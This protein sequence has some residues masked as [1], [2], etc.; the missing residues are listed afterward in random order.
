MAETIQ[1]DVPRKG[2][3]DD[4]AE[5]LRGAGLVAEVRDEGEHCAIH[6]S[7]ADDERSRLVT[8]VAHVVESWLGEQMLPL[9]VE[10]DNGGVAVRPPAE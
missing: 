10:R 2:I 7:Y 5:T 6:V 4:L 1:V 3:G 8:H 9:V